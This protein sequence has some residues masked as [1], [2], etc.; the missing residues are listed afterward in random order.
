MMLKRVAKVTATEMRY[1]LDDLTETE[2]DTI[3]SGLLE[4]VG[5]QTSRAPTVTFEAENLW[6]RINAGRIAEETL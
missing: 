3:M 5:A 1:F 6:Y 2:L 4:L